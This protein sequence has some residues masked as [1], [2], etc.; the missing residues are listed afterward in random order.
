MSEEAPKEPEEEEGGGGK[1]GWGWQISHLR[2][3]ANLKGLR[4]D[5]TILT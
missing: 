3:F 5:F 1:Q 4:H 2:D